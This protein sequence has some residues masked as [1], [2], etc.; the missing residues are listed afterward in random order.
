MKWGGTLTP[1][2]YDILTYRFL[3][4]KEGL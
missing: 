1:G 3:S 4:Q 2:L